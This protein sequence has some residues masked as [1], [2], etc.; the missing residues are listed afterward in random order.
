MKITIE[1]DCSYE[2][3]VTIDGRESVYGYSHGVWDYKS[4]LG[5]N[6]HNTTIGGMVACKL[7]ENLNEILQGYLP[8]Y[9]NPLTGNCYETWETLDEECADSVYRGLRL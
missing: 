8:D 3:K 5:E 1:T 4:G 7:A 2:A 9:D 6:E